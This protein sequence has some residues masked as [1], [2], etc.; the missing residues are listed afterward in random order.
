MLLKR[1]KHGTKWILPKGR[2]PLGLNGFSKSNIRPI[3]NFKDIKLG[4]LQRGTI[5]NMG[6]IMMKPSPLWLK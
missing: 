6:L 1:T 5:K 3:E 4:L 2:K